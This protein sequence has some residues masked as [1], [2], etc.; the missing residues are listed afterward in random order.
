[1]T[2]CPR[3]W[4]PMQH[5]FSTWAKLNFFSLCYFC[6]HFLTAKVSSKCSVEKLRFP[7]HVHAESFLL[8]ET[9]NNKLVVLF[10]MK[11]AR[12]EM[13]TTIRV[14]KRE[15]LLV[16]FV[17]L[18]RTFLV[19]SSRSPSLISPFLLLWPS[20]S[21]MVFFWVFLTVLIFLN[22]YIKERVFFRR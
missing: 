14:Q 16:G 22:S 15:R 6:S 8:G 20:K 11:Y 9:S 12:M 17:L 5:T 1:M 18:L 7:H 4:G 13:W 2:F 10:N 21:V 19:T 3:T